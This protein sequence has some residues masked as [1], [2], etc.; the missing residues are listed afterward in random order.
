MKTTMMMRAVSAVLNTLT[1]CILK[2]GYDIKHQV[3]HSV[4]SK[5]YSWTEGI[6]VSKVVANPLLLMCMR[7]QQSP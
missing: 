2:W 7:A 4:R 6:R 5:L 1:L 3:I